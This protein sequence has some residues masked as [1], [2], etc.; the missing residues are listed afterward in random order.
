MGTF[1]NMIKQAGDGN[2]L[3]LDQMTT[4]AAQNINKPKGAASIGSSQ[5][6]GTVK[7]NAQPARMS[8][9]N[10]PDRSMQTVQ[11]VQQEQTMQQQKQPEQ[12]EANAVEAV[13]ANLNSDSLV[14]GFILAEI[15]GKP[16]AKIQRGSYRWNSRF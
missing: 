12:R 15:L 14:Q 8:K 16:K 6:A 7:R 9:T 3:G 5:T 13:L 2:R 11:P 1:M 4:L 10:P